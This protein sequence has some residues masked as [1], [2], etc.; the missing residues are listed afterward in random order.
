MIVKYART[1]SLWPTNFVHC[2]W[3]TATILLYLQYI[4]AELYEGVRLE[5]TNESA[6]NL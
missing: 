3:D 2:D 1:Q 5:M 4:S 6:R